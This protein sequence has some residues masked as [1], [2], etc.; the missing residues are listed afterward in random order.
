MVASCSEAE[1]ITTPRCKRTASTAPG[2]HNRK[3]IYHCT[4]EDVAP[5]VSTIRALSA[6]PVKLSNSDLRKCIA[7]ETQRARHAPRP[8]RCRLAHVARTPSRNSKDTQG[9]CISSTHRIQCTG[10]SSRARVAAFAH[11][12]IHA[13]TCAPQRGRTKYNG[14]PLTIDK[15]YCQR[16]T[17]WRGGSVCV[18]DAPALTWA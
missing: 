1:G 16:T 17:P 4:P 2:A 8:G 3:T 11:I 5:H 7:P 9:T 12:F 15:A 14:I 13:H 18:Q 10:R 6:A